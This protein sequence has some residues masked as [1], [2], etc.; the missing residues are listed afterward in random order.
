MA[1]ITTTPRAIAT[2]AEARARIVHPLHSVRGY[3]RGYVLAE[4][5]LVSLLYLAVVFWVGLTLDFG[6]FKLMGFI[7][8]AL[9][10][11]LTWG[12]WVEILPRAFRAVV[13]GGL[14]LGLFALVFFK[15]VGRLTREFRDRA[16]ALV[17]ERRFPRLLGDRLITAVELADP[18]LAARYGFSQ[19][20]IDRTVRDAAERV[21]TVPIGQVFNWTRLIILT[22]LLAFLTVGLYV[23]VGVAYCALNLRGP[24]DFGVR[25][26]HV[27]S[28]WFERNV[29]LQE[30]YWPRRAH[31]ELL[32]PDFPDDPDN[33]FHSRNEPLPPVR[34]RAVQWVVADDSDPAR[35]RFGWRAL[36]WT[37]LKANPKRFGVAVPDKVQPPGWP[38]DW[39][40]TWTVD[41]VEARLQRPEVQSAVEEGGPR[42][43]VYRPLLDTLAALKEQADSPWMERRFRKLALPQKII[44]YAKGTSIRDEVPMEARENREYFGKFGNHVRETIRFS[45]LAEDFDT[46]SKQ[47]SLVPPPRLAR[48]TR[49]EYRPAYIYHRAPAGSEPEKLRGL[50][51]LFHNL[52]V[53]LGEERPPILVPLGSDLVLTAEADKPLRHAQVEWRYAD[54][55]PAEDKAKDAKPVEVHRLIPPITDERLFRVSFP[56]VTRPIAVDFEFTDTTRLTGRRSVLIQPVPD[57]PPSVDVQIEVL[58]KTNQGYLITAWNLIPFSGKVSDDHGLRRLEYVFTV[59][60]VQ[61]AP[62]DRR[63]LYEVV[64]SLQF[65]APEGGPELGLPVYLVWLAQEVGGAAPAAGPA[66]AARVPLA[67]FAALLR[68]KPADALPLAVVLPAL[69]QGP[70][71][72]RLE[73]A[74]RD[75]RNNRERLARI[76]SQV[77][78]GE[79]DARTIRALDKDVALLE[80]ALLH[81]RGRLEEVLGYYRE[82]RAG[83]E[84]AH[85][86]PEQLARLDRHVLA[87]LAGALDPGFEASARALTECRKA[88]QTGAN[89]PQPIAAAVA[90]LDALLKPIGEAHDELLRLPRNGP[91]AE[92]RL[93]YDKNFNPEREPRG[94]GFDLKQHLPELKERDESKPQRH[95]QIQMWV[96]A[97]DGNIERHFPDLPAS[98]FALVASGPGPFPAALAAFPGRPLDIPAPGVAQSKE[99][100]TLLVVSENELLND[101]AKEEESLRLKLEEAIAMLQDAKLKLGQVQGEM[102]ALAG[103][104]PDEFRAL[105]QVAEETKDDIG[106][107]GDKVRE[108]YSDYKRIVAQMKFARVRKQIVGKIETGI[109]DPLDQAVADDFRQTD[110]AFGDLV[111]A[112]HGA[113][114]DPK[115]AEVAAQRLD[116][117]IARLNKALESM[118]QVTTINM[119]I[120]KLVKI[121]K[122]LRT[123][124]DALAEYER[125]KILKL[126][127]ELEGESGKPEK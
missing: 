90:Q 41:Q 6:F 112:L 89:D 67:T 7:N 70:S 10:I 20:M 102:P 53:A 47:I 15:V 113:N 71:L 3:I 117:L 66:K 122:S 44:L 96:E 61:A 8:R 39:E 124:G 64:S 95:Y 13:L 14:L 98:T 79:A 116:Q 9:G 125:Q 46:P 88:L 58:R 83:L 101:I 33:L 127:K 42:A 111:G 91:V 16:L 2:P 32:A 110:D 87:P 45:V 52:D 103:K 81:D 100:F 119:L 118:R 108:I 57:G 50:K 31:L 97:T 86:A 1:T 26:H 107:S 34:V 80:E 78:G 92:F 56:D 23:A 19:A 59:T 63:A 73:D 37:D 94:E 22:I 72:P 68:D 74:L 35:Y 65:A 40:E 105:G 75:L 126:Y 109:L 104:K 11:S 77:G 12:D 99:T 85:T 18:R 69:A 123:Q 106:R 54:S 38:A 93:E 114:A 84:A 36:T 27:A 121:E 17:L 62:T 4:G 29:L 82:V 5:T 43:D 120:E 115:T 49:D 24:I 30:V 60:D 21:E 25:F 76:G 55:A 48:L 28:I 51:H